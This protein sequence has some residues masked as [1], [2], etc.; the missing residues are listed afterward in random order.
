MPS[1]RNI[2]RE[3]C[4]T[5]GHIIAR[6]VDSLSTIEFRRRIHCIQNVEEFQ[7]FKSYIIRF[8]GITTYGR[9]NTLLEDLEDKISRGDDIQHIKAW[10]LSHINGAKE[11]SLYKF[12]KDEYGEGI[13]VTFTDFYDIYCHNIDD[14]L[15]K[16]KVSRALSAF[17]LKPELEK[18]VVGSK[19]TSRV[20]I[21]ADRDTLSKLFQINGYHDAKP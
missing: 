9:A 15:S 4:P 8:I 17:G 14:S 1:Q 7:D 19:R 10:I 2:S 20:K 13:D 5:C 3:Y 11:M 18:V 12:I 6:P 16:N 21:R